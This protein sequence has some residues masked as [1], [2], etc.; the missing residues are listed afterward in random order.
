M[1]GMGGEKRI[2]QYL[3]DNFSGS[4]Q[5]AEVQYNIKTNNYFAR[6]KLRDDS[7]RAL[8]YIPYAKVNDKF[9]FMFRGFYHSD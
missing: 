4:F 9:A 3:Q 1:D 5:I 2:E 7:G 6:V 8:F